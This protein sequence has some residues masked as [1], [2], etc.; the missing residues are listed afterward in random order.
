MPGAI[1][2]YGLSII[3]ALCLERHWVLNNLL[4]RVLCLFAVGAAQLML[5][6]QLLSLGKW[7][8]GTGLLLGN[9]LI[10]GA[11]L[12]IARSRGVAPDRVSCRILISKSLGGAAALKDPFT[13]AL[14]G[15]SLAALL[16]ACLAG[17]LM[18]PFGD[19]YHVEM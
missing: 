9:F 12:V 4:K 11:V 2:V 16:T 3:S 18:I 7:L 15:V 5:S 17:W 14:I 13:M 6:I 19:S 1:L 8:T 10:T